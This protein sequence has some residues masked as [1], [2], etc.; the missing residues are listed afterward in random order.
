[1]EEKINI[2]RLSYCKDLSYNRL[3]SLFNKYTT[4][5]NIISNTKN[6]TLLNKEEIEKEIEKNE[7]LSIK[8]ITFQ[9]KEYPEY[10]KYT[11]SFPF[12]LHCKGNLE[13]LNNKKTLA[14]I[15]SRAASINNTNYAIK[16]S[17]ELTEYGYT[18][19]SGMAK[20]IDSAAHYGALNGNTIAV[21]GGGVD[22]IYP[23][24]NK[25]LY[26]ELFEKNNLIISEFRTGMEPRAE[27]FPRRNRII[28]GLSKGI[29]IVE[30]GEKSGTFHTANQAL[31]F[32]R[33]VM[34][35]PG[36]PYDKNCI[37]SN[38]L[39]K[40]GATIVMTISDILEAIESFMSDN[41]FY[42]HQYI[43]H[44]KDVETYDGKEEFEE[45]KEDVK[46]TIEDL[47]LSK[48]DYAPIAIDQFVTYFKEDISYINSI[49]VKLELNNKINIISG[50]VNLKFNLS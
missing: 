27:N 1:M 21:L 18:I 22:N 16:I 42:D 24:E 4:A 37:G 26:N 34:V 41:L 49:L 43:S 3:L 31:K 10:L 13:L 33:E 11:D 44:N 23:K 7:K 32:N 46:Q 9:D 19:I 28:A 39:I 20:G 47:I 40:N 35:L 50:K 2:L 17:Q 12:V 38:N 8:I 25:R 29:L 36:S 5:T 48:L 45:N 14:I 6:L 15:G 30:A